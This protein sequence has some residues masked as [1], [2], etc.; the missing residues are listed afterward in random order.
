MGMSSM[1]L[2]L[3]WRFNI[4]ADSQNHNHNYLLNFTSFLTFSLRFKISSLKAIH[5]PH[6]LFPE[7]QS[8]VL[9]FS[10]IVDCPLGET[11]GSPRLDS[12]G[13]NCIHLHFIIFAK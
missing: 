8:P 12:R 13:G 4:Y 10:R 11:A 6:N 1:G 3:V 2:E 7:F 9:I 5:F